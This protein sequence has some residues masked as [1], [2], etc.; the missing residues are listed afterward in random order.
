MIRGA[1][2][3]ISIIAHYNSIKIEHQLLFSPSSSPSNNGSDKHQAGP[4]RTPHNIHTHAHTHGVH[5]T[6]IASMMMCK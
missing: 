5:A 3:P 2:T 4:A 1:P 6:C